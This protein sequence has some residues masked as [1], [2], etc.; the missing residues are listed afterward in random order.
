M[1]D[2]QHHPWYQ[3]SC[4]WE[5][6]EPPPPPPSPP[7]GE[8]A[9]TSAA[10]IRRQL[11]SAKSLE[12]AGDTDNGGPARRAES[13][14]EEIVKRCSM[15]GVSYGNRAPTERVETEEF[16]VLVCFPLRRRG[17]PFQTAIHSSL[18]LPRGRSGRLGGEEESTVHRGHTFYLQGTLAVLVACRPGA[19]F[20]YMRER[21]RVGCHTVSQ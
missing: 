5:L 12:L 8:R 3:T 9:M 11:L 2:T 20:G 13:I 14:S 1:T 21:E 19:G 17:L 16:G 4:S 18:R 15:H 10:G 7:A 6:L